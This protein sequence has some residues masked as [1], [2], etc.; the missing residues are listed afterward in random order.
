MTRIKR[1]MMHAPG[2]NALYPCLD[3]NTANGMIKPWTL[4]NARN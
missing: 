2:V 3:F 4:I 1:V